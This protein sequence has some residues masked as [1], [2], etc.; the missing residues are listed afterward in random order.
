MNLGRT[1]Q[2]GQ[3]KLPTFSGHCSML[4]S[5]SK[6]WWVLSGHQNT[7]AL[8]LTTL[9]ARFIMAARQINAES[10]Y[11]GQKVMRNLPIS[12]TKALTFDLFI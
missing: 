3:K 4:C 12:L 8:D 1:A 10:F 6:K 2:K 9:A 11:L 7:F 5:R